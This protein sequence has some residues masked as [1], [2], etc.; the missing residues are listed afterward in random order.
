MQ[1]RAGQ[2]RTGAERGRQRRAGNA[3]I[4]GITLCAGV[5]AGI[6]LAAP[7]GHELFTAGAEATSWLRSSWNRFEENYHPSYAFDGDPA[8]GWVEGAAGDGEGERIRWPI[9]AVASARSV[10]LEIRSGYH[11]S[12]TLF[13]AN[14]APRAVTVRVLDARGQPVGTLDAELKRTMDAQALTVP[15]T[16][17]RAFNAVEIEI[18]TV[19]PG[20]KYRDTVISDVQTFVDS[21]APYD[22]AYE[23]AKRDALLAWKRE[24]VERA[25]WFASVPATWPWAGTHLEPQETAIPADLD[26]AMEA[27]RRLAAELAAL[28]DPW[29]ITRKQPIPIPEGLNDPTGNLAF[30]LSLLRLTDFGLFESR[31]DTAFRQVEDGDRP[32]RKVERSAARVRWYERGLRPEAATWTIRYQA[33]SRELSLLDGRTVATWDQAGNLSALYT[34]SRTEDALCE[35]RAESLIRPVWKDG[36]I[37]AIDHWRVTRPAGQITAEYREMCGGAI[38]RSAARLVAA[39]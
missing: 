8:T 24:R 35:T 4:A 7:P 28:P 34:D 29:Q 17:G 11:K 33:D 5:S 6:A 25:A 20:S 19:W 1:E 13:A 39:P 10:S 2:G 36:R 9:S 18:R 3:G 32:Y 30:G 21:D 37:T 15:V 12:Q 23:Q 27:M 38:E 14:G 31:G 22:A 26:A 16:A